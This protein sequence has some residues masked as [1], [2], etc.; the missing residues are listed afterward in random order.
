MEGGSEAFVCFDTRFP[1]FRRSPPVDVTS[2]CWIIIRFFQFAKKAN[3]ARADLQSPKSS[4]WDYISLPVSTCKG[5]VIQP[6]RQS[7]YCENI[8]RTSNYAFTPW[9]RS[10]LSPRS[11]RDVNGRIEYFFR[12]NGMCL[13]IYGFRS[14]RTVGGVTT[15]EINFIFSLSPPPS[16][17]QKPAD[18]RS[19]S[20]MSHEL[21]IP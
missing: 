20:E 6:S 7:C 21:L 9:R 14:I 4:K 1:I 16:L 5:T 18:H 8:R 13:F 17:Q 12:L 11:K 2:H 10:N 19:T 3:N 15:T